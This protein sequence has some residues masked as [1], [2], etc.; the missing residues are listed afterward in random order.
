MDWEEWAAILIA[1]ASLTV[2]VATL[3]LTEARLRKADQSRERDRLNLAT[4]RLGASTLLVEVVFTPK[5]AHTR[6]TAELRVKRPAAAR[7]SE[8][9]WSINTSGQH[10]I[11]MPREELDFEASHH[12]NLTVDLEPG[13]GIAKAVGHLAGG[14]L[15]G[16][17]IAVAIRDVAT[18]KVVLRAT[19]TLTA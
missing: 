6:Y 16:L 3:I 10:F 13:S 1:G 12:S 5:G 15:H 11:V 4:R 8:P 17:T 7:L 19:E 9:R 14:Q 2:S 18:G